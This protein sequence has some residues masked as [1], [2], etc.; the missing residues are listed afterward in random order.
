LLPSAS[1]KLAAFLMEFLAKIA[2]NSAVNK[3]TTINLSTVWGPL[4]ISNAKS[5]DLEVLR[6]AGYVIALVNLMI[7]H[8]DSIFPKN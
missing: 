4:L 5:L 2:E 6:D 3:M 7:V 1:I 8:R